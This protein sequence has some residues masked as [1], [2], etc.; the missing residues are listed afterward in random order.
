MLVVRVTLPA[1]R[2]FPRR[3]TKHFHSDAHNTRATLALSLLPDGRA[4]ILHVAV[5][6][7]CLAQHKHLESGQRATWRAR[8]VL[9]DFSGASGVVAPAG[10]PQQ[11][12]MPRALET[13]DG[14]NVLAT[15]MLRALCSVHKFPD[16]TRNLEAIIRF[17]RERWTD[18]V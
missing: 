4:F 9:L 6:L 13:P 17:C 5:V 2:D 11:Y 8:D 3:S 10:T 14:D 7:Q 15:V 1:T 16:F 12:I 18:I